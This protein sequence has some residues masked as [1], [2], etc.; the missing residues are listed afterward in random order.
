MKKN[1]MA[2]LLKDHEVFLKST[3]DYEVTMYIFLNSMTQL[4]CTDSI[5]GK[6]AQYSLEPGSD[7]H[8][9]RRAG[10]RHP[11]TVSGTRL[12]VSIMCHWASFL[13][14]FTG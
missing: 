13:S 12:T 8:A 1:G 9:N 10:R 7:C 2:V 5:S 4:T 6:N 3:G 14:L 11:A